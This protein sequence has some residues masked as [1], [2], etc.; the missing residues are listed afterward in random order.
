[1][2][3]DWLAS[4]ELSQPAAW[5]RQSAWGYP[6]LLSVHLLGMGALFGAV[7]V[8]D[9][10]LWRRSV[11]PPLTPEVEYTALPTRVAV[12]GLVIA[13]LSGLWL[14]SA[15]ATELAGNRPF[16][17]KL[18]LIALA[19][20]NAFLG[21]RFARA[22]SVENSRVRFHAAVSVAVWAG[23]VILGRWIGFA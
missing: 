13:A 11:M 17:L 12:G 18:A 23:V 2:S 1:M 14:F 10:G 9:V 22:A 3:V 21:A 8:L 16:Q 4:L 7:L 20:L 6:T 5:A 15:H 19:G